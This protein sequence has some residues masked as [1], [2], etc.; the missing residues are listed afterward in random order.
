MITKTIKPKNIAYLF[1][2]QGAQYP[3][4][5]KDFFNE[6]P[7]ARHTYEE[8]ND[9]LGRNIAS[10]AF[11]GPKDLLTQ[12]QNSQLAIFVTSV[13][14]L[15]VLHT[16]YPMMR[17][18]V[19]AGLSLGEYTALHASQRLDFENC[20]QLVQKR[21]LLMNDACEKHKGTMAVILGLAADDVESLVK[22]L[23]LPNDLWVANFNCP[24]QVVISGTIKGVDVG[25]QTAKNKGARRVLPLAVHGAFHSGL[26]KDAEHALAEFVLEAPLQPS[27]ISLVMNVVGDFV[28][29]IDQTKTHLINQVSGSVRWH[30][31]ICRMNE[32]EVDLYLEIGCGKTLTGFN[33][34]IG[35]AASTY[36]LERVSDFAK[37]EDIM[38]H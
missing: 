22:E 35:V 8:A 33:E 10:I 31:G 15:R 14:M 23:N 34:K 17:P 36:S 30:Q 19:C 37:L 12:T 11:E 9:I 5:G 4:M 24:G 1:P 3:G 29:G 20:L 32:K 38:N 16:L 25:C 26:M 7:I 27:D 21:A 18:Q 28:S 6:F 2:G 13:A